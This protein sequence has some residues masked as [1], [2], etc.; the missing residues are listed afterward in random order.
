ML[1]EHPKLRILLLVFVDN[2]TNESGEEW[3]L[4]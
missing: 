2:E 4:L 3:P 1:T